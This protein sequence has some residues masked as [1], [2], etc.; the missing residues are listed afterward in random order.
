MSATDKAIQKITFRSATTTLVFSKNH[1]NCTMK[2]IK[3][4]E[5]AGLFIR[6][7]N[8][9]VENEVKE[10]KGGFLGMLVATLASS[11]WRSMLL[12]K[13]VIPACEGTIRAG[14]KF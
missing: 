11:L 4:L 7:I 13:G 12:G 5:C 8:K 6:D 9:T 3:S 1:L 2:M 10:Q 14:Q